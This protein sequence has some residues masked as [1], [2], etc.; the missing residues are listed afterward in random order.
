ITHNAVTFKN[1]P[2]KIAFCGKLILRGE[3]VIS[4]DDF[5]KI[6]E[7]LPEGEKYK[8]PRNLCSGSIRQLDSSLCS[9]RKVHFFAF[10]LVIAEG[11]QFTLKSEKLEFLRE[12]GFSVV[13]YKFVT[14][15]NIDETVAFFSENI[16]SNKF[17]SDGLVL[18]FDDIAF[19][20]SL[21]ATSKFPK[22]SIAFKWTD[23]IAET[24]LLEIEWSV[25]RTGLINPIAVFEPVEIEGTTV[26]RASLHNLSIA[27]SL[28]LG[29][30]DKITVYKANMIIPQVAENLTKSGIGE[31]PGSCPV[32]GFTSEITESNNT[33]FLYCRNPN[34]RAKL[35][36]SLTH[37]TSRDAMNIDGFSVKKIEKFTEKNFLKNYLDI[38]YLKEH[39]QEI[40]NMDGF[41]K[42][43]VDN[44]F[45]AIEKS[46]NAD[47]AHFIYALG[48]SQVGLAGA[49]LLCTHFN[50]DFEKIKSAS[51]Q[52]LIAIEGFGESI[53]KSI[54]LYF[55]DKK[56]SALYDA[57]VNILNLQKP[58]TIEGASFAG[59]SFVI[60]GDLIK[61]E[62]RAAL[63]KFIEER[64][65]KVKTSV[66]VKTS[67]L[68]NNDP[69]SDS[70]KNKKAI[71][72][73]IPI[74]SEQDFLDMFKL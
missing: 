20:D 47:A 1:L 16:I 39:E 60:T 18:T 62:N 31:I 74:I 46:K 73:N 34:C 17:A 4:Y 44:L 69:M 71:S 19:S 70:S 33:K 65:G 59:K 7:S 14:A 43:S 45:E 30:G 64:G 11:K 35:V 24:T 6:N 50:Y 29:I 13:Q 61:F 12:L 51:V 66:S 40:S 5:A 41:G 36:E 15:E 28:E 23:E 55:N 56:N 8:N 42:K 3:S 53:A 2:L 38:Y 57:A 26:E 49:K 10:A 27:Q 72:L 48:I 63:Q 22:D 21:G 54:V 67:Y 68:I 52:D 58:E 32:C 37:F 25:S 9:A